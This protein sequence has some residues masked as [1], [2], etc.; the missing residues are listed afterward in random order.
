[1][2]ET[3][4]LT[5]KHKPYQNALENAMNAMAIHKPYDYRLNKI[6]GNTIRNIKIHKA[7]ACINT[8]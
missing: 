1:M 5:K 6:V 8:L 4:G 2:S 3:S 7:E